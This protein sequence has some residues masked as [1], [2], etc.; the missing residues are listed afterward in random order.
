M[1]PVRPEYARKLERIEKGRFLS[2]K[3]L[4]KELGV[5]I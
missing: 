1:H 4:E 2:K 3:E 5:G